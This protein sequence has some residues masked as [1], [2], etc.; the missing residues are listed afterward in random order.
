MVRGRESGFTVIEVVLFL[1]VSTALFVALMVGIGISLTQQRYNDGV[2][3]VATFLQGQYAEVLNTR[4]DRGKDWACLNSGDPDSDGS[5]KSNTQDSKA[6]G[7]T[8]CVI[9]G[10]AIEIIDGKNGQDQI[11]RSRSITGLDTKDD[12]GKSDLDAIKSYKPKLSNFAVEEYQVDFAT[13]ILESGQNK[14]SHLSMAIIRSPVT[15]T[16]KV[17]VYTA[18]FTDNNNDL[19]DKLAAPANPVY[20]CIDGDRGLL[21]VRSI[22]IDPLVASADG[23]AVLGDADSGVRCK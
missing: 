8:K 13:S 5:V 18:N 3:G 14:K 10:R 4:N 9:L 21:P 2:A 20:L 15:G 6:R 23:V 12:S 1:A 7:T 17:F 22:K 19:M 16:L 11:I